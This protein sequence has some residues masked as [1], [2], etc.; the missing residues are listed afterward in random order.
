MN[1]R[2]H[3]MLFMLSSFLFGSCTSTPTP[4]TSRRY[5]PGYCNYEKVSRYPYQCDFS[6]MPFPLVV[7]TQEYWDHARQC[8]I[9]GYSVR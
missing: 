1:Q 7:D 3:C 6:C 2:T 9:V 8:E 4:Q 5:D